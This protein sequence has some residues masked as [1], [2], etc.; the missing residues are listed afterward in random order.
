MSLQSF[1]ANQ[2]S[3]LYSVRV[4]DFI[5]GL[6]AAVIGS[7]GSI[8]YTSINAGTFNIDW[9]SV[10]HTALTVGASYVLKQFITNSN[11]QVLTSEPS[12]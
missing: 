9:H 10:E 12:K 2:V 4:K 1:F 8:V 3:G 5:H 11:G 7:V 6:I